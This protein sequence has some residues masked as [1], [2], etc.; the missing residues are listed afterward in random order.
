MY[1]CKQ[2][3]HDHTP[4]KAKNP[5][6]YFKKGKNSFGQ[7]HL[8]IIFINIGPKLAAESTSISINNNVD[9]YLK[10]S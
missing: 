9:K 6:F 7:E 1:W 3:T 8:T 5:L 10:N 4:M 2:V